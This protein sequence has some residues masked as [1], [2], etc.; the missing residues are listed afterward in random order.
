MAADFQMPDLAQL[1]FLPPGLNAIAGQQIQAAQ[2]AQQQ[3]LAG[4]AQDNQAKTIQNLFDTQNNP[5]KLQ[6]SLLENENQ[7]MLNKLKQ[8]ELSPEAQEARRNKW[9]KE[10]SDSKLEKALNDAQQM[11]LSD[12]PDQAK[13]G[14]DLYMRSGKEVSARAKAADEFKKQTSENDS[15]ERIAAGNNAATRYTADAASNSRQAVAALRKG[16]SDDLATD[17]GGAKT[18]AHRLSI[19]DKYIQRANDAQDFELSQSLQTRRN[20]EEQARLQRATAGAQITQGAKPDPSQFGFKTQG[21]VPVP[22][23][24]NPYAGG[25]PQGPASFTLAPDGSNLPALNAAIAKMPPADRAKA[26]AQLEAQVNAARGQPQQAPQAQAPA[27]AQQPQAHSLSDV[28][29]MYPGIPAEK[30]KE[31]YKKKFGVDLQ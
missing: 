27:A 12:D 29:K 17:L 25:A 10:A 16:V 22:Q 7:S 23:A 15:R 1:Q 18:D 14:Q 28:Q 21:Q 8:E 13:K 9:V 24:V 3:G 26:T 20:A 11:M 30:L 4:M 2:G 5:N 19:Y 31:V 6:K